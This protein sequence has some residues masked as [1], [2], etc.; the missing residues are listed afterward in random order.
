MILRLARVLI[1][2]PFNHISRAT[3]AE[4]T[5]GLLG[6]LAKSKRKA[7]PGGGGGPSEKREFPVETDT[8]KLVN[9][10]CGSNIL[11]EG[12]QDIELKPDSEYPEWLWSLRTGPAPKLEDLDPSTKYYWLLL[13]RQA[14]RQKNQ[15]CKMRRF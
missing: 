14:R 6:G 4:T 11:K 8:K 3:Y 7:K 12:G 5:S 13:R 15:L 9:F 10:V 2:A 1:P